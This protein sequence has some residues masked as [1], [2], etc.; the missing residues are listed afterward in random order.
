M[1]TC[2]RYQAWMVEA[3]YGELDDARRGEYERAR[4]VELIQTSLAGEMSV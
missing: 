2:D 1:T 3:L 4:V